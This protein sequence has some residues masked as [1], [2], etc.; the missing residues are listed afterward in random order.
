MDERQLMKVSKALADPTRLNI[1]RT[2][3]STREICCGEI[4][5][6]FPVAQA[7]VSHHLKILTESG[8]IN[9]QRKGQFSYFFAIRDTIEKYRTAL[10]DIFTRVTVEMGDVP[11]DTS[12]YQC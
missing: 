3:A 10:G 6:R 1:L 9:V 11:D 12:S 7:T 5:E 2:I 4:A 8:L